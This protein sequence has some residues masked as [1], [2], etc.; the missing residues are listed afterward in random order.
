MRTV[1]KYPLN[2]GGEQQMP[3]PRGSRVLSAIEQHGGIVVYAEVDDQEPATETH[4][5]YVYGT[6][7]P[8][9]H[10]GGACRFLSTVKTGPYVFHV[11][12]M[13]PYVAAG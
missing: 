9:K 4:T 6:G 10:N 13:G 8:V 11:Y 3:L 2:P 1:H 5:L 7:F 12:A